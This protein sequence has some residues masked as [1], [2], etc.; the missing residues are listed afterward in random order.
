M[1]NSR[2]ALVP[3]FTCYPNMHGNGYVYAKRIRKPQG[4]YR[5]AAYSPCPSH[6]ELDGFGLSAL[7][8]Q[9]LQL[10]FTN[11]LRAPRNGR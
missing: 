10:P 3:R 4:A 11:K 1:N 5:R 7:L 6:A 9:K 8:Y 2:K